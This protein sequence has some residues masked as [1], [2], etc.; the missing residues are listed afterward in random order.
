MPHKDCQG[1]R[2]E[3]QER[4]GDASPGS[5]GKDSGLKSG[6]MDPLKGFK[7]NQEEG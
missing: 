4:L 5:P 3:R 1:L 7:C 6:F 2:V